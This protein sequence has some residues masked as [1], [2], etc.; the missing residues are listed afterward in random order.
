MLV[1]KVAARCNLDCTYCYEYQMGDT[2]WRDR[3][4][5]LSL[6]LAAIVGRRIRA[7]CES[8][9]RTR[10]SVSLHGGEPLLAGIDHIEGVIAALR[11]HA[12]PDVV[13]DVGMQTNA[14]LLT[15]DVA[16]RL[17]A[18]RCSVGV[19]L[20][21]AAPVNDRRRLDHAGRGSTRP[22]LRGLESLKRSGPRAFS[23]ILA[24][25]DVEADPLATFE[26]LAGLAP[27]SLDLLLPH[28]T[29]NR[30][31]PGRERHDGTPYADWLIP[32]FDAWFGGRHQGVAIRTFE[33]ILEHLL[34][35]TGSLETLGLEPVTL[36]AVGTDGA[37]EG[38]DTLK[39]AF[40]GAH[41]LGLNVET[42]SLDD[43]L[44][45]RMVQARQCGLSA[46]PETCVR[47]PVV[48]TCGGGYFPHRYREGTGFQNPSVYCADLFKL[49]RH[50]ECALAAHVRPESRAAKE[51]A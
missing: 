21:G 47:C 29:W 1:V 8:W 3:P 9:G 35:G 16:R 28:G 12:G 25:I 31:P 7:H 6:E 38:V 46:L 42:H 11:R 5:V 37:I 33:E 49:I 15:D 18:A 22:A 30:P 43:A 45:H 14:V 32:I 26:F 48:G 41:E 2:S 51:P 19:S 27:P 4:R 10:F 23:G 40:P 20:D 44:E 50:I 36:L 24:V 13:L 39:A 17:E 34:G